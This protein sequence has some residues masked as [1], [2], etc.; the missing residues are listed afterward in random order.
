MPSGWTGPCS[1]RRKSLQ[2]KTLALPCTLN[3]LC[4]SALPAGGRAKAF[5]HR[6][7]SRQ[8]PTIAREYP[9]IWPNSSRWPPAPRPSAPSAIRYLAPASCD[10]RPRLASKP[11][12]RP[13][14]AAS[15]ETIHRAAC[16]LAPRRRKK[17]SN[18]AA[19][20]P[21]PQFV[22]RHHG[23]CAQR[24]SI[25]SRRAAASGI[26]KFKLAQ[27]LAVGVDQCRVIDEYQ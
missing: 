26:A 22:R 15:G 21:V 8:G 25:L 18:P 13:I 23:P 14:S 1:V 6:L 17:A 4:H 19:A 3:P 24:S 20:R 12:R 5:D 11:L 27:S 16:A 9:A 7:G 10:A 2:V